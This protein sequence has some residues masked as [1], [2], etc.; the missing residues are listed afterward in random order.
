MSGASSLG[1]GAWEL[2]IESRNVLTAVMELWLMSGDKISIFRAR[3]LVERMGCWPI[4][5]FLLA[6]LLRNAGEAAERMLQNLTA[7]S[8]DRRYTAPTARERVLARV[9]HRIADQKMKSY[10]TLLKGLGTV[11]GIVGP[12]LT[13]AQVSEAKAR[14]YPE[15]RMLVDFCPKLAPPGVSA[16]P[17]LC[18]ALQGSPADFPL[19]LNWFAASLF[20]AIEAARLALDLSPALRVEA[21]RC[22]AGDDLFKAAQARYILQANPDMSPTLES[23]RQISAALATP[24]EQARQYRELY[25]GLDE[26]RELAGWTSACGSRSDARGAKSDVT[27]HEDKMWAL[28]Q[29]WCDA[30]EEHYPEA[31]V[32]SFV[33]DVVRR[34]EGDEGW[35]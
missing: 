4:E 16:G 15:W 26:L 14:A 7:K 34:S 17:I 8:S 6:M 9:D 21:V 20:E 18:L 30:L 13:E 27:E 3:R 1:Q 22:A 11:F 32:R 19:L 23:E 29:A 24:L 35:S 12:Y 33:W 28:R 10:A 31:Q 25:E 2:P 5:G